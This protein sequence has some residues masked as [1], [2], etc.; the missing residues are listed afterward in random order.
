M[1]CRTVRELLI[2]YLNGSLLRNRQAHAE[3]HL[4]MCEYCAAEC[5]ELQKVK[6]TIDLLP[7]ITPSRNLT[8]RI[9]ARL[10]TASRPGEHLQCTAQC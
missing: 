6:N 1:D 9:P 5:T 8:G 7:D 2:E 3:H 10:C 4:Q